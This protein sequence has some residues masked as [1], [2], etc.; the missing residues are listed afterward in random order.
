MIDC[1][2]CR[3]ITGDITS[4]KIYED[5]KL[6]VFKDIHPKAE[7]HILVAPKKHIKS[8]NELTN[9]HQ[10]LIS[11]MILKLSELARLQGL[12][13]GFRTIIHTGASGGQEVD[14]LHLHIL[15]GKDLSGSKADRK[16]S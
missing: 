7:V 12:V 13:S 6:Y 3:I 1:L 4:S 11:T 9:E 8:L 10:D 14:H 16:L 5:E 2:F 15:G